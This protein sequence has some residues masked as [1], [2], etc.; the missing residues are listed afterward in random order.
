ML[1]KSPLI[2]IF[3][4]NYNYYSQIGILSRETGIGSYSVNWNIVSLTSWTVPNKLDSEF[5]SIAAAVIIGSKKSTNDA[6]GWDKNVLFWIGAAVSAKIK[7]TSFSNETT[8][9]SCFILVSS[10][11]PKKKT[12]FS[13]SLLNCVGISKVFILTSFGSTFCRLLEIESTTEAKGEIGGAWCRDVE[14]ESWP[15]FRDTIFFGVS[16]FNPSNSSF[17]DKSDLELGFLKTL[18][19][20]RNLVFAIGALESSIFFCTRISYFIIN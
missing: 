10:V 4:S 18:G 17:D 6:L 7:F 16:G 14:I 1:G 8:K 5:F 3:F 2:F 15:R 11:E 20:R 12:P 13:Q 9:S 19:W